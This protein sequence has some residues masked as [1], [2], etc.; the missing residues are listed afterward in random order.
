MERETLKDRL[1]DAAYQKINGPDENGCLRWLGCHRPD[2]YGVYGKP[3]KRV[4]RMV[5]EALRGPI[6]EDRVV[7]HMCYVRDC[8]NI[9]HL[10]LV[11]RAQNIENLSK[12]PSTNSSGVRGVSWHTRWN[13]WQV[14][15]KVKGK[16]FAGGYYDTLDE[17]ESAAIELRNKVMTNNLSDRESDV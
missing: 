16:T 15:A 3:T 10:Q 1:P 7:D 9:E 13:K 12:P 5:Y 6:P 4:H 2:G 8:V 14:Q 17:A 11:T